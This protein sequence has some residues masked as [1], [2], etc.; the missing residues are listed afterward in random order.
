[1]GSEKDPNTFMPK[2]INC[3]TIIIT[4]EGTE[5]K[6][7]KEKKM[8]REQSEEIHQSYMKTA[9]NSVMVSRF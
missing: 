4:L 9:T 8:T 7:W 1:M 6:N 2:N 5:N 3:I